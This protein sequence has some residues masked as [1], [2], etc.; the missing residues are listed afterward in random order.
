MN[1]FP[2]VRNSRLYIHKILLEAHKIAVYNDQ[3]LC[4]I[5]VYETSPAEERGI[6]GFLK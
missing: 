2:L 4:F 5:S 3:F 6:P 1:N